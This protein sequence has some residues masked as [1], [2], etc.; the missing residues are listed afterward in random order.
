MKLFRIS[1]LLSFALAVM[2]GAVLFRVSQNVQQA[3]DNLAHLKKEI[4]YEEKT[5]HVLQ[6]EWAYLNR[7]ARLEK[8]A[9]EHLDLV[10]VNTTQL[11]K[12]EGER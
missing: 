7:P 4:T 12:E 9:G 2:A 5:I 8:L 3:E 6:A 1:T 10:P 11:I